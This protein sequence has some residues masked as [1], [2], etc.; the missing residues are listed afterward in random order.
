[1]LTGQDKVVQAYLCPDI[2]LVMS[3]RLSDRIIR[4][5]GLQSHVYLKG[6]I[7]QSGYELTVTWIFKSGL[8]CSSCNEGPTLISGIGDECVREV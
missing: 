5:T 8:V 7:K 6:S 1:M 2:D 3:G 4:N